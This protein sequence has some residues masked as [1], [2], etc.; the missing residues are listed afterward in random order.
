MEF[1][2]LGRIPN[3]DVC[4]YLPMNFSLQK[5]FVLGLFAAIVSGSAVQALPPIVI[6]V[7][8]DQVSDVEVVATSANQS[9]PVQQSILDLSNA[10]RQDSGLST[11]SFSA[12]LN[13]AA[14]RHAND[15]AKGAQ[16][17]HTGSDGSTMQERVQ[18]SGYKYWSI[19]ENIYYQA[20]R[21]QPERAVQGWLKSPG[22]RRNLLNS[23]FTQMGVGYARN[24][25]KHYYVQVFGTPQEKVATSATQSNSVPQSILDLSNAARQD[26]ELSTL[27][28][29][30]ALNVAAQRHAT[31]LANG[32][33]FSHTGSDGSTM[34]ERV[35]DSGYKYWSIAE[36]IYYQ[37]PENQPERAVQGWLNSPGHRRN[38]LNAGFT[39]MGVGYATNGRDHYYVQVFGTPQ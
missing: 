29:A 32:A 9:N 25:T 17:S 10:A 16:F 31:D 12:E 35:Q 2:V 11:L 27:R 28:F 39:E 24:G 4:P 23:K 20:P 22:H 38:L 6:Q 36:N 5:S 37:A 30:P 18:D 3:P 34:K 8:T 33:K 14:Q 13:A 26:V 19:A 15:L 1:V 7:Q 21:N